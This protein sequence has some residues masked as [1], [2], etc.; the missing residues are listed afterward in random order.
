MFPIQPE[1]SS[2]EF[3]RRRMEDETVSSVPL[4]SQ[5]EVLPSGGEEQ[6]Y[7]ATYGS[8]PEST[9]VTMVLR[10][11][12][13]PTSS[14]AEV[15]LPP[16]AQGEANGGPLGCCLGTIVGLFLTILLLLGFSILL[17]NGGVL[18]FATIPFIVAGTIAGGFGG[19][20]IGKSVFKEYQPPIV[21]RQVRVGAKKKKK[22]KVQV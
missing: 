9:E 15:T 10:E 17:S 1:P 2:E 19:W 12:E 3:A 14:T 21:K 8:I 11:E 16:E 18:G 22:R 13:H 5:Q 7:P 6:P 20:K 4:H